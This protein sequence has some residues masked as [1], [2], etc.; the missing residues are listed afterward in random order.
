LKPGDIVTCKADVWFNAYGDESMA[1]TRHDPPRA[2]AGTKRVGGAN[3]IPFEDVPDLWF[4]DDGFVRV[5]RA[6]LN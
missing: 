3:F 6:S 4:W 1:V 5:D 2:V